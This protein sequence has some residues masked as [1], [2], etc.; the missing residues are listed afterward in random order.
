MQARIIAWGSLG[1]IVDG[2]ENDAESI[3]R[4]AGVDGEP[5]DDE[6]PPA[7]GDDE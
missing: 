3:W 5:S 6:D 4:E 7:A 2:G 1:E